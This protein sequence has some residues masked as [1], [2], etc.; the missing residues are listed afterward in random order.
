MTVED[1]TIPAGP[2]RL[3][4]KPA[5]GARETA[6]VSVIMITLALD[7]LGFGIAIPVLPD[8]VSAVMGGREA[9]TL[10][11]GVLVACYSL[12]QFVFA[13]LLGAASDAWGRRPVMMIALGGALASNLMLAFAAG[14]GWLLAGRLCAGAT[15]ASASVATAYLADITTPERRAAR[16]G[17]MG[18]MVG[19]GLVA[20]PACGGLLGTFG[21]SVPFVVTSVLAAV[22]VLSALLWLPES[23]PPELR[24]PF[25]VSRANPLGSMRLLRNNATLRRIVIAA[26][27]G[28][29]AYG[30]FL[31]CFVLSNELRFG[32]GSRENG[33]A[34]GA[35]GL[36]ITLT[37]TFVMRHVVARCGERRTALLGYLLFIAA[38]IAYGFA[39]SVTMMAIAIVMHSLALINDPAMRALVSIEA[40]PSRQGEYLGAMVCLMELAATIAP[41]FGAAMLHYVQSSTAP[42]HYLGLPFFIAAMLYALAFVTLMRTLDQSS[43]TAHH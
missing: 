3:A 25:S 39:A 41:L 1:C 7:A 29:T 19:L 31:A 6:R 15:A 16:F 10:F 34:L 27:F 22:N 4:G 26:C 21:A 13:P 23:H 40:G 43:E 2:G 35:L 37:Q 14:F 42:A 12:M 11:L 9:G 17:L 18:G 33:I 30:I 8:Q 38:Y 20:G 36:G 5:Q 32:W 24:V 28:M